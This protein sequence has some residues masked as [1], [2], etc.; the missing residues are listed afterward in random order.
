MSDLIQTIT[1]YI[2][3]IIIIIHILHS[4]QLVSEKIMVRSVVSG[5]KWM[6]W[7]I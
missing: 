5:R 2:Q 7:E 3:I 6:W 4:V 1:N